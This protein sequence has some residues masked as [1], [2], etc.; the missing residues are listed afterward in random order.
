MNLS[1]NMPEIDCDSF[2]RLT[3]VSFCFLPQ[4][5]GSSP[6]L[7]VIKL[8]QKVVYGV[9]ISFSEQAS[10]IGTKMNISHFSTLVNDII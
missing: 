9:F 3:Y 6:D 2:L 10:M 5:K 4:M 8:E 7:T 1:A